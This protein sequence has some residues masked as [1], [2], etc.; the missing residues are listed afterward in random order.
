MRTAFSSSSTRAA[1]KGEEED[2]S[3]SPTRAADEGEENFVLFFTSAK[4]S[5][6][7]EERMFFDSLPFTEAR[8]LIIYYNLF[9]IIYNLIIKI[10]FLY[11]NLVDVFNKVAAGIADDKCQSRGKLAEESQPQF[12]HG[13]NCHQT[14]DSRTKHHPQK[15]IQFERHVLVRKLMLDKT[16]QASE[17]PAAES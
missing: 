7:E 12:F 13:H 10:A 9:K 15:V 16:D 3:S 11:D 4:A 6:G 1:A 14:D 2:L 17:K 5:V 8:L